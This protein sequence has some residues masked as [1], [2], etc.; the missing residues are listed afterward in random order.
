MT[1]EPEEVPK[2]LKRGFLCNENINTTLGFEIFQKS[3]S[4][5]IGPLKNYKLQPDIAKR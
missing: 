2:F 3:R 1:S 5:D 4:R